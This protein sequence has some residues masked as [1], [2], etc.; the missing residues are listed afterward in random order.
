[1]VI[2]ASNR[3]K[4]LRKLGIDG[5]NDAVQK[6]RDAIEGQGREEVFAA[7]VKGVPDDLKQT[8]YTLAADVVLADGIVQPDENA[9]LRKVQEALEVPDELATKVIEVMRIKNQG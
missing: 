1:M 7:A 2:A 4:S 5:F 6:I 3:M 9:W 8:V